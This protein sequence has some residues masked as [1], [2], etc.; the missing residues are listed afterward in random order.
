MPGVWAFR[1]KSVRC[2]S[3]K[4]VPVQLDGEPRG[5][6]PVTFEIVPSAVKLIAP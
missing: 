5:H 4:K 6:L 2:A 1:A 3:A